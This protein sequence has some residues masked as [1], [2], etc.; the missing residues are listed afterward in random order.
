MSLT[1]KVTFQS[2]LAGFSKVGTMLMAKQPDD[3]GE[4]TALDKYQ[5]TSQFIGTWRSH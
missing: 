5:V 1:G 4:H 2:N 3:K